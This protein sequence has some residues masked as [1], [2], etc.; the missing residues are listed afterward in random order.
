MVCIFAREITDSLTSL[1]KKVDKIVGENKDKKM[2]AFVVLLSEDPDTAETKLKEFAKKHKIK[3]VPLT[4]FEGIA[5]PEDYKVSKD[6]AVT[7]LI[8]KGQTIKANHAFAKGKLK[9]AGVKAVIKD[10]SKILD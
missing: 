2:A 1:V 6:A 5:G 8:W 4:I 7:V 9:K 10:T 3:N